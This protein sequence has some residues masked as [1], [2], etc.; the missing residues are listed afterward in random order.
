MY[1]DSDGKMPLLDH[2]IELRNRL[3]VSVAAVLVGFIVCYIFSEPIFEFLVRPLRKI[4][5]PDA[6]M[7]YTGLHEAFFTYMK[8]AFFAGLFLAV[9]VILT[10]FWRFVAPGLY[11][12]ERRAFLPFLLMTPLLFFL[13]G[14]LAYEFVFPLAF[15]FFLG[16][17]SPTIEALPSISAYLSLVITLI[18]A[19]GLVAEMPLGLLLLIKAGLVSTA[20]LVEKRRYSIVVVFIVAAILTPPD[21]FSQIFLALP[22]LAMYEISILL[23]RRI[24]EKRAQ[25]E[26]SAKVDD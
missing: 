25:S 14:G 3:V 19:F 17:A 9:P 16:F 26:E 2:L 11:E 23:G 22:M 10:Q 7:I 18:F 20:W 4:L 12:D 1:E 6:R 13:G 24:E 8:V 5:G 15:Q 21:P